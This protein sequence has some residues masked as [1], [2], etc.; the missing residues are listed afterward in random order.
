LGAAAVGGWLIGELGFAS[1]GYAGALVGSLGAVLALVSW[2]VT[3]A[4]HRIAQGV[5]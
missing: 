5:G 3:R 1:L 4:P 2:W